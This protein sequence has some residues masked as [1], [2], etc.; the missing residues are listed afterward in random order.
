MRDPRF[1]K[2]RPPMGMAVRT[3]R[4]EGDIEQAVTA[5]FRGEEFV[6]RFFSEQTYNMYVSHIVTRLDV[7][8]K[9]AAIKKLQSVLKEKVL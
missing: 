8:E 7:E 5:L 9:E 3:L 1:M 4:C 6:P 2:G